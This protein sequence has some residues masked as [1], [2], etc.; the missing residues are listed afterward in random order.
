MRDRVE[1]LID[2]AAGRLT[3]VVPT[4]ALGAFA[5][6]SFGANL[7][8]GPIAITELAITFCWP[9][10]ADPSA[11]ALTVSATAIVAQDVLVERA[12]TRWGAA[13]VRADNVGFEVRAD[14]GVPGG[15]HA[16]G[17]TG[18][19]GETALARMIVDGLRVFAG[20]VAADA[21][22][23]GQPER[24]AGFARAVLGGAD[25]LV[26]SMGLL[27]LR[28]LSGGDDRPLGEIEAAALH[29]EGALVK[30]PSADASGGGNAEEQLAHV[31]VILPRAAW[32]HRRTQVRVA[33]VRAN[34][35][36]RLRA[37]SD[38]R[39]ALASWRVS[40]ATVGEAGAWNVGTALATAGGPTRV[41]IASG[42]VVGV[43]ATDLVPG[44][45]PGTGTLAWESL[46]ATLALDG[47][48]GV[49]GTTGFAAAL[50][51][52]A[53][54]PSGLVVAKVRDVTLH[55][56][57]LAVGHAEGVPRWLGIVAGWTI[58]IPYAEHLRLDAS[59]S[60]PTRELSFGLDAASLGLVG[61]R[62]DR[63]PERRLMFWADEVTQLQRV[64]ATGVAAFPRDGRPRLV[65]QQVTVQ[66]ATIPIVGVTSPQIPLVILG[67]CRL[68]DVRVAQL[69]VGA[70]TG[71]ARVVRLA[72]GRVETPTASGTL[73]ASMVDVGRAA[74]G[75]WT[76]ALAEASTEG[77]G[78]PGRARMP[79]SGRFRAAHAELAPDDARRWQ[80]SWHADEAQLD[81]RWEIDAPTCRA[82]IEGNLAG[83]ASGGAAGDG[84][85]RCEVKA[86]RMRAAGTV[87]RAGRTS[88]FDLDL[89]D[90]VARLS[91]TPL[92]LEASIASHALVLGPTTVALGAVTLSAPSGGDIRDLALRVASA[93][94]RGLGAL[95]AP[96]LGATTLALPDARIEHAN[97]HVRAAEVVATGLRA[98]HLAAARTL[99]ALF[100][101]GFHARADGV[102]AQRVRLGL[103]PEQ[104]LTA[105][106]T[107]VTSVALN[108][109]G[110]AEGACIADAAEVDGIV[111]ER[112]HGHVRVRA[113]AARTLSYRPATN[114][115]T[116]TF[117]RFELEA[118]LHAPLRHARAPASGL[119][120]HVVTRLPTPGGEGGSPLGAWAPDWLAL[121]TTRELAD[122][123]A[124]RLATSVR[125]L[126][127]DRRRVVVYHDSFP[128]VL[129]WL[130][131][132]Q[133]ITV[134]PRPGIAPDPGHV[135]RVLAAMRGQGA[136]VLLQE[137]YY[138]RN[139]SETVAR[140][141]PARLVVLPAGPEFATGETYEAF[142]SGLG[143]AIHAALGG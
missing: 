56:T 98:S 63:S 123:L 24:I 43:R 92:E 41:S 50:G 91:V 31:R 124:A 100:V 137:A 55:P 110:P 66:Q 35:E 10:A 65:V 16:T 3:L 67:Q 73:S 105:T 108:P 125:A 114:A 60:M 52:V 58:E 94:G 80:A 85:A 116:F 4:L 54:I 78:T 2:E 138:P 9:T 83:G 109:P 95:S 27:T 139:T 15:S 23:P 20:L 130:G 13:E 12:A 102:Q 111:F 97:W 75:R 34:A 44:A 82:R 86:P 106:R 76:V 39:W 115:G 99:D 42:S 45:G 81:L 37:T 25:A 69:D 113:A 135:A 79:W 140:L 48:V 17:L 30:V 7:R 131:L 8:T 51:Q 128:Y 11:G 136:K 18:L 87:D 71:S 59:F 141:A 38:G 29:L 64:G 14:G 72:I 118:P 77:T 117:A 68:S 107:A 90:A 103:G 1:I 36:T 70:R 22:D 122:G 32:S 126:P 28:G 5:G 26:V 88:V 129:D 53:V 33:N 104:A 96:R 127:E 112:P 46:S 134:E 62:R 6:A 133:V 89:R 142:V 143:E 40:Q 84:S 19:I 132:T 101:D 119:Q 47:G 49:K 121:Q 120:R 57:R 93:R 21:S 61:T 74:S